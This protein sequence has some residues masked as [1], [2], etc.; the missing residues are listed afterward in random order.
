LDN[1]RSAGTS[2]ISWQ[3]RMSG[4]A[5][6]TTSSKA[7][8]RSPGAWSMLYVMIRSSVISSLILVILWRRSPAPP[9]APL[10]DTGH[11]A[12]SRLLDHRAM[13]DPNTLER[14]AR[15]AV[16]DCDE[17]VFGVSVEELG[18][19]GAQAPVLTHTARVDDQRIGVA[20]EHGHVGMAADHN[21]HS[22]SL[23]HLIEILRGRGA[24]QEIVIGTRRAMV[25]QHHLLTRQRHLMGQRETCE[26][27]EV[28][29]RQPLR[30]PEIDGAAV[31]RWVR[32]STNLYRPVIP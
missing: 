26:K 3:A 17:G 28:L 21:S 29:R 4:R 9:R 8:K 30:A 14:D 12:L 15:G 23:E 7:V 16:V 32:S 10:L 5:A 11:A 24:R 22:T 27:R 19:P 6:C 1:V 20:A 13:V 31:L 25:A 18:R 2:S